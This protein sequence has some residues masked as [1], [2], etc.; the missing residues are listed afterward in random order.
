[1]TADS[2]ITVSLGALLEASEGSFSR[3]EE[4]LLEALSTRLSKAPWCLE[5]LKLRIISADGDLFVSAADHHREMT[6]RLEAEKLSLA[7]AAVN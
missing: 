2:V 6:V 5:E 1:M 4:E 3:L 7:S